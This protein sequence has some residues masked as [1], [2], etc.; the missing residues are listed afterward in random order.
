MLQPDS[1]TPMEEGINIDEITLTHVQE[2][3]YLDN[4]IARYGD[5][6]AEPQKRM[7]TASISFGRLRERRWNK[8][9]V[10]IR[11]KGK[12]YRAIILSIYLTVRG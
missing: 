11:V 3:T 8:Y 10:S 5:I 7:S 4:N 12:I 6:D 2:F 1:T 9:N